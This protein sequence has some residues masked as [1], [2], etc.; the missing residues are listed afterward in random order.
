MQ[1]KMVGPGIDIHFYEEDVVENAYSV[2]GSRELTNRFSVDHCDHTA[3]IL[4]S[5][6]MSLNV[7]HRSYGSTEEREGGVYGDTYEELRRKE[8]ARSDEGIGCDGGDNDKNAT[9][10]FDGEDEFREERERLIHSNEILNSDADHSIQQ[11]SSKNSERSRSSSSVSDLDV[12]SDVMELPQVV[13]ETV[14]LTDDPTIPVFT[15]RYLVLATLFIV[16]GAFIDTLNAYR[17]TSAAYSIFFVQIALHWAG[18]GLAAILPHKSVSIGH[19]RFNLNPGPWTIK[20]TAMVTITANSGATGNMATSVISMAELY[21]GEK[22][23]ALIAIAFMFAIVFV[24]YSY[25]AIAKTFL[26]HDVTLTWPQALMQ[27]ALFQS[28]SKLGSR[29]GLRQMRIFFSVLVGVAAWQVMPECVFPMTSSLA[30]LCW[31]APDNPTVNF[32]GSG[33]GGMGVMNFSLDWANI[34]SSIMLYPY[35]IQVI[36]FVAFVIG[37]WVMIPLVKWGSVTTFK[38]GLMSNSLF[39]SLGAPYPTDKLLTADLTLN[40]TAYEHYGPV[41]LGAQRAW[42]MFFDYA[43]YISGITWVI[44]FG[45]NKFQQSYQLISRGVSRTDRLNKLLRN[46]AEVPRWW[47][48]VLF[49]ISFVT[50]MTILGSGHMFM[51]WWCCLVALVMGSIIVT[52]LAWL[53]ALSNFQLAIGTFN[54][55]VYGYMVQG[56]EHKHPAGALVFGSIAGNAWYRAQ[57][58][59]EC[60]RL[61]FYNHL[62]P[63]LVFFSQLYGEIIGIPV[64]YGVMRWVLHTKSEYLTGAKT[65]PLHQW[66]GQAITINHTNAIQYVVLGPSRLF[67]NYPLLPYGFVLGVVAPVMIAWLHRR[68]PRLQFNYWNTTVFFAS[69][70]KFYGNLSTGYV[71]KFIG[72]TVTMYWGFRYR[73]HLWKKYN[74][75]LAAAFDTGYNLTVLVLF[76]MSVNMPHWWGNNAQSVERCFAKD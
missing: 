55:L 48:T 69:M 42:N 54:E 58:H 25:A 33:M 7:E 38:H 12:D 39:T 3:G 36:Q 18:K 44:V 28:Q 9:G 6:T 21:F 76:M 43:A 49:L 70:A 40:T 62:P 37:A 15:L 32:L 41:H 59:L 61:G 35:W 23:P 47:Y 50:L 65:D 72:G 1:L 22:I 31:M 60:M 53:Y 71:S 8:Y 34:T 2:F 46:Y 73:H 52:P 68:Y 63:R 66:T 26:M 20:E 10:E 16:P 30:V 67:A 75:I 29:D 64:N 51:P 14:P 57:Y 17:T 4:R 11:H 24:G 56:L 74:Y 5:H 13:R 19:L 45:M 27:T